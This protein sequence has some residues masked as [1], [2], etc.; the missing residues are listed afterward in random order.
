MIENKKATY[1]TSEME[2]RIS[3]MKDLFVAVVTGS[4]Y[5]LAYVVHSAE[6]RV[7]HTLMAPRDELYA[8]MLQWSG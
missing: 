7:S 1:L 3:L 8:R 4:E 2:L 5:T 6:L